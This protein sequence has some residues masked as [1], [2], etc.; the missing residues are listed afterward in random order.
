MVLG[1]ASV[2][3]GRSA[4]G[5]DSANK[6]DQHFAHMGRPHTAQDNSPREFEVGWWQPDPGLKAAPGFK[7]RL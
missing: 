7:V 1:R 4:L 2:T 3:L 6:S 5:D